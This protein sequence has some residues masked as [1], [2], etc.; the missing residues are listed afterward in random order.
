MLL[1][2]W[3]FVVS[4]RMGAVGSLVLVV[5][6]VAAGCSS[7]GA[8]SEPS[9]EESDQAVA[10]FLAS[11]SNSYEQAILQG[12]RE[13]AASQGVTEVIEFDGKFDAGT[14]V[15]QIQDAVTAGQ[16]DVFVIEPIDPVA[17]TKPLELAAEAGIVVVCVTTPC[18]VDQNSITNQ[19]AGQGGVVAY[20]FP[21]I[22]TDLGTATIDACE[23]IDPCRVAHI[24]GDSAF[25]SDRAA[26]ETIE[27]LLDA[28]PSIVLVGSV[29]GKYDPAT[30]RQVVQDLLQ[31]DPDINVI[32]CG[33][34]Q[35]CVGA[36][37][38]VKAAGQQGEITFISG[39]GSETAI[40]RVRDGEWYA[41]VVSV[42]RTMAAT[43]T[44]I[45]IALARGE[46]PAA[47]E[48]NA[49]TLVPAG[50]I[51]TKDTVGDFTAEWQ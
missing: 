5:G 24:N 23:G 26:A 14:Q 45:G 50:S 12:A 9:A 46:T 4:R 10:V 35:M 43:A 28:E 38:A 8:S 2:R 41:A 31:R 30:S 51:L 33:S 25:P 27:A 40:K 6:L 17:V 11:S 34:D 29:D 16:A 32:V 19:F 21:E 49:S 39:G 1:N 22:A 36:E 15:A 37:Q 47:V 48:V 18:G 13:A 44:E 7:G 42:P 3:P 20:S